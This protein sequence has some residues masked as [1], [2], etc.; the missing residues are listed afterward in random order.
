MTFIKK[1]YEYISENMDLAKSIFK[2]KQDE[3]EKLKIL[4]SKNLG[5]IR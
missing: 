3:F 2:K 4:L 1:Y 5:Y